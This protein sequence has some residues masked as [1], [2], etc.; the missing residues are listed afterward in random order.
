M[1]TFILIEEL[2]VVTWTSVPKSIVCEKHST[3][4]KQTSTYALITLRIFIHL[5]LNLLNILICYSPSL[6]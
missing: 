6:V 3:V 2:I 5:K 4:D 1:S